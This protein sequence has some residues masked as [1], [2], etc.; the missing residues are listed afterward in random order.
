MPGKVLLA[1]FL[2]CLLF[3]KSWS[4]CNTLGQ[5]PQT[6]FPVCG[7][8]TFYQAVVPECTNGI[9]QVPGCPPPPDYEDKNPFW[10]RFTC[11]K[12]GT[13]GFVIDPDAQDDFDDY[14]W[15]LFDITGQ[16]PNAVY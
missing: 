7:L 1:F 5:T 15:Q 2:L 6:A 13:L 8:D 9:M 14:D 16:S 10:Y 4:Q 11:Y 3:T 12:A